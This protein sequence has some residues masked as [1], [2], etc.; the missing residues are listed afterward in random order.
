MGPR[1]LPVGDAAATVE[2]GDAIDPVVNARVRSLD[3]ALGGRPFAGFQES[4]PTYRSLLV[5]FD[6]AQ[7]DLAAVRAAVEDALPRMRPLPEG[8]RVR[9]VPTVYGGEHGPDLEEVASGHGLSPEEVIARHSAQEYTAFMLGF[10]PGFAYLGMVP[11]GLATPRRRTPRP[12]VPA[13]SVALAGRQTAV[14]PSASPG[15]WNLIGRT[16]LR[17]FDPAD[18]PPT[19]ILP[20]DRVRFLRVDRWNDPAPDAAP[21]PGV[22]DPA[23]EVVEEGLLTTVQDLGRHGF[24]RLG[25]PQAGALDLDALRAANGALGNAPGAAGLECVLLGPVLRF[26]RAVSFAVAGADLGAVLERPDLGSWP[27]PPE[28]P[29]RARPGNLLAFT[30]R[31]AGCRAY[32]AFAGGLDVPL[33]LGSRSTDVTAGL[34]GLAGRPVRAGDLLSVGPAPSGAPGIPRTHIAPASRDAVV[35]VVPGPQAEAFTAGA[36]RRLLS[37]PFRVAPVSDRAGYRLEGPVVA[38]AEGRGE[39]VTDAMVP[40]CIQVPPDGH[41]I[42][43]MADGPTTGGY[44]KI[45]TVVAADLPRLAQLVP[46]EGTVRFT[47]A[48]VRG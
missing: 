47:L 34:G 11:E 1:I 29:V 2:L 31:R 15:G 43:V 22:A 5:R 3:Q 17:L 46:G 30:G 12:R 21:P 27:V 7:A 36:H 45:A 39:A 38:A 10:L 35:R 16:A 8:G 14:Y 33:V 26:R 20:G 28:T 37:E 18:D 13:G 19:A 32:V 25:V 4:V 48:E 24:R 6:P 23:F 41:P 9:T 42:V 44:P 40:G